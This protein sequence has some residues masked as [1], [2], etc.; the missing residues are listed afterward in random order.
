MGGTKTTSRPGLTRE[1]VVTAALALVDRHGLEGLTMRSLGEALS[2]EAMSLY[3]YCP[4]KAELL[5]GVADVILGEMVFVP[6]GR[7]W[8]ADLAAGMRE[9]WRVLVA[10]PNAV[11]LFLAT[12]KVSPGSRDKTEGV[13]RL[14]EEGG[15]PPATAHQMWRILQAFVL[16]SA[17][18]FAARPNKT[19]LAAQLGLLEPAKSFP[20]T[21]AALKQPKTIDPARDFDAGVEMLIDAIAAGPLRSRARGRR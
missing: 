14:L 15:Y 20:R 2:V 17:S 8:R 16:G 12:P 9:Y 6:T 5:D 11:P 3:R 10:H 7:G 21:R 4:S 19:A 13:L 1:R 18:M